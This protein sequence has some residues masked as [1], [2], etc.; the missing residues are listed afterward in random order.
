[1]EA[2]LSIPLIIGG[3]AVITFAI[4]FLPLAG[5][6]SFKLPGFIDIWLRNVT[7]AILSAMLFQSIFLIKDQLITVWDFRFLGALASIITIL[8]TRNLLLTVI[9][10]TAV[11]GIAT[12]LS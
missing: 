1:M 7:I 4:R 6:A 2:T 8:L 5:L 10:G 12:I 11:V 3:M 9:A